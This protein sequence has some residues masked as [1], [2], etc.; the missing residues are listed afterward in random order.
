MQ[1]AGDNG[2]VL[3]WKWVGAYGEDAEKLDWGGGRGAKFEEAGF[4]DV[5]E[6]YQR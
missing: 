2:G 6:W 3:E 5:S 4:E 1:R